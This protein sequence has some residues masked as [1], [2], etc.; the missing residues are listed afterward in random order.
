MPHS[1]DNY[2]FPP[3]DARTLEGLLEA[4]KLAT[5]PALSRWQDRL[6]DRVS[7][8]CGSWLFVG[9]F[10]LAIM[11]WASINTVVLADRAF[12]GYPFPFLNLGLSVLMSLQGPLILMSQQ[13]QN[14]QN[15]RES[16]AIYSLALKAEAEGSQRGS[17]LSRMETKMDIILGRLGV[18]G[19]EI[20]LCEAAA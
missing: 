14:R 3:L 18:D 11:T 2:V 20:G 7:R 15:R 6:A 8:F 16:V 9:C 12:D 17:E 1:A 13:R 5:A 4:A 19:A 10:C